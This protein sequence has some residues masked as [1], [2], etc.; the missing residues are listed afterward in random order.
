MSW[1]PAWPSHRS[2]TTSLPPSN[3]YDIITKRPG[4]PVVFA[5]RCPRRWQPWKWTTGLCTANWLLSWLG[6]APDHTGDI[7]P[8]VELLARLHA[9]LFDAPPEAI[10]RSAERRAQA[11]KVVDRITGF[12][13][14]DVTGDRQRV[15]EH[16][17]GS[18]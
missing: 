6:K 15:E 1:V 4:V 5:C 16:A 12:Y 7:E 3:T 10:C 11:A 13:S 14:T 18:P 9:A 8:M 2:T 17:A